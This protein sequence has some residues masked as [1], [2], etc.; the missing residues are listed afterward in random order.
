MSNELIQEPKKQEELAE[1]LTVSELT[2]EIKNL[3]EGE[4]GDGLFWVRGEISNFR[5]KGS[6]GHMYFTL[7]DD[8]AVLPV[9]FFKQ[10]NRK[11]KID[12]EDGME[13]LALGRISVYAPHGRYQFIIEQVKEAG[14]GELHK[15]FE[16]LKKKLK[17]K[18]Y[19]D[20]ERKRP[21]PPIPTK[22]GIV[23]S[24]T[25]AVIRDIL[26]VANQ[27][28]PLTSI[29][30][31]PS[32]VQGDSAC[33]EIASGIQELNQKEHGCDVIIIARGGGSIEDLWPFNEE[34]VADAIYHSNI[35]VISAV[36]HQTDFTISDFVADVRAATP[37]HAAEL[38]FP[39]QKLFKERVKKALSLIANRL[40]HLL[41][42]GRERL[43]SAMRSP[44]F[45]NPKILVQNRS[46]QIDLLIDKMNRQVERIRE[47]A[48]SSFQ[49]LHEKLQALSP[50]SVLKRGYSITTNQDGKVIRNCDDVSISEQVKV[51]LHKG[52]LG[53]QVLKKD[54]GSR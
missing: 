33:K 51:H 36:G 32:K 45:R 43:K 17:A 29:L 14:L 52:D 26:K 3:L 24:K 42:L 38:L 11:S 28:F 54:K 30:I 41:A 15:R 2:Q 37:S 22:V 34:V 53:C 48:K 25:G 18:G 27:R 10:S 40:D 35:P 23:T 46:Q 7:K 9:A 13:V 4:W 1:F 50:F 20:E 49:P 12:L 6:S 21:L 31:V 47:K 44:S 39:D 19:F 5:G 16:E 8:R